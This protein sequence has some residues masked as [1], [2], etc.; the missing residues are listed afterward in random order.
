MREIKAEIVGIAAGAVIA[1]LATG[2]AGAAGPE[3]IV[4]E[5]RQVQEQAQVPEAEPPEAATPTP[6]TPTPKPSTPT[7]QPATAVPATVAPALPTT[8]PTVTSVPEP[9]IAFECANQEPGSV[10][11]D[12]A[13][14]AGLAELITPGVPGIVGATVSGDG[15]L[16]VGAAGV[17]SDAG[18]DLMLVT[19]RMHLGSDTKAMTGT[20]LALLSE[21]GTGELSLN[22]LV[23][24]VWPAADDGWVGVTLQD[25][26]RH[27]GGAVAS[28]GRDR[29]DL[30]RQM[31][32]A[33]NAA[34]NQSETDRANAAR[35][36]RANFAVTLTTGPPDEQPGEYAYSNA[37]YMLVGAAIEDHLGV[38]WETLM[39]EHLFRPLQM[40][41]CGFGIPPAPAPSGHAGSGSDLTA[42]GPDN[43]SGDNPASLGPAGTVYC[44]IADWGKYL[45]WVIRG[46]Q[47]IDNMLP[48]ETWEQLLEPEGDYA[49]GWGVT[50]RGWADG[51]IYTHVGSNTLWWAVTWVAPGN[52]RAY[53]VVANAAGDPVP[54]VADQAIG[55][56]LELDS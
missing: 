27:R 47:G 15:L 24:D 43:P 6:A 19:D 10:T 49:A 31:W 12:A 2:C 36:Y 29:P 8:I 42:Y 35:D 52:D 50:S 22:T 46:A 4:A 30:W 21:Q 53:L 23:T 13:V 26:L 7:P 20:L 11:A 28:L 16:N 32:D 40:D 44:P 38:P 17:R 56:L 33:S 5:Q 54:T 51:P 39:C 37:G 45:S 41:G 55:M 1:L 18:D 3:P 34:I 25:L 48:A 14:S 9:D